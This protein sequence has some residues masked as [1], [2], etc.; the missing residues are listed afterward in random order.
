MQTFV[1]MLALS[2]V[3][4]K[5]KRNEETAEVKGISFNYGEQNY[6]G[7]GIGRAYSFNGLIKKGLDYG[8]DTRDKNKA[9]TNAN[10]RDNDNDKRTETSSERLTNNDTTSITDNRES[11]TASNAE[12]DGSTSASNRVDKQ[13]SNRSAGK[14]A[15]DFAERSYN[16][17]NQDTSKRTESSSGQEQNATNMA[18]FMRNTVS[19]NSNFQ[20]HEAIK[21]H[22]TIK[23]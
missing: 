5:L 7:T 18:D 4:V 20:L 13:Q 22:K 6:T 1:E 11:R 3:E 2:G 23:Y 19:A 17:E 15:T 16:K 9:T 8:V 12:N 10:R 14:T 21:K